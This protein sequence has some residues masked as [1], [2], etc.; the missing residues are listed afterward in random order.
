MNAVDLACFLVIDLSVVRLCRPGS[1][2]G[3]GIFVL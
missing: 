2:P 1:I 3:G